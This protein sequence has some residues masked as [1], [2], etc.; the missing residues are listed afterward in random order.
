MKE[1]YYA[2]TKYLIGENADENW[3]LLDTSDY[4]YYF[5]HL[6]SFPSCYVIMECSEPTTDMLMK[7]A[8]LCKNSTKY[9]KIKNIKI[10]YCKCSNL[11]KGGKVGEVVY[12]KP[13]QVKQI[14]N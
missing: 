3:E 7:G 8:S 12:I 6:A 2:D 5:F 14:K 4:E 10:D 9:K 1:V 13:R 11:I